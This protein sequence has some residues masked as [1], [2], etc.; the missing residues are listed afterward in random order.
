MAKPLHL[1]CIQGSSLRLSIFTKLPDKA[2]LK[3]ITVP[4]CFAN[5]ALNNLSKANDKD[6]KPTCR[7]KSLKEAVIKFLQKSEGNTSD[8]AIS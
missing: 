7:S 5:Q 3:N 2:S 4:Y 1:R 8:A 6:N